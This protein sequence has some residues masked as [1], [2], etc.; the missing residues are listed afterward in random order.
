MVGFSTKKHRTCVT[1]FYAVR[2]AM[3][4]TTC[5]TGTGSTKRGSGPSHELRMRWVMLS[6]FTC[7][8]RFGNVEK[9]NHKKNICLLYRRSHYFLRIEIV[10]IKQNPVDGK[11]SRKPLSPR[12]ESN[13]QVPCWIHKSDKNTMLLSR[14]FIDWLA[15]SPKSKCH[16]VV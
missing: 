7:Y 3:P 15:W 9:T 11:A 1:H 5:V 14:H 6:N 8:G 12:K 10:N 16:G 4:S 2:S 13:N